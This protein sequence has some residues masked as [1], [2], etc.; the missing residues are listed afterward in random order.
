M[1][2]DLFITHWNEPWEIGEKAF[3]ML[4]MQRLV[5]WNEIRVTLVHDGSEAFPEEKFSGCPFEVHQVCLEHG[6]IAKAR[7]WCIDHSEAEWIK[8]CDFDDQFANVYAIHHIMNVLPAEQF[9]LLWFDLLWEIPEGELHKRTERNP[10]FIHDKL[11]RRRF[12][13]EHGIRFKEDL[14][15]CEDSAFL[16]LLEMI[17]D[18]RRIGKITGSCPMYTWIH[19]NGSLCNRPEIKFQNLQSFFRRH[20]YV[21]EEFRKRGFKDEYC[22]MVARI[23]CDSYFTLQVADV[24]EDRS[25]HEKKVWDYLKEHREQLLGCRKSAFDQVVEATNRENDHCN[26]TK[27]EVLTWLKAMRQ[28]YDG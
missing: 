5:D 25:E 8:W 3:Q 18:V 9:D 6:G 10:V 27:E 26:I 12:L 14:T 2:L 19:R 22:T 13:K 16:S 23:A 15:W 11:F 7:N 20:C 21:A 24:P 28:K 17:I 4:A 1:L